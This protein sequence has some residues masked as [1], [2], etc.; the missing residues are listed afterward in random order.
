MTETHGQKFPDQLSFEDTQTLPAGTLS[1]LPAE[2]GQI[3]ITNRPA[4]NPEYSVTLSLL[5]RHLP[6]RCCKHR[7]L[8]LDWSPTVDEIQV[9]LPRDL[10][11]LWGE[12]KMPWPSEVWFQPCTT[13]LLIADELLKL[14]SVILGLTAYGRERAH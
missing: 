6:G 1:C 5:P 11:V 13:K 10:T 14:Y 3:Q 2:W 12:V 4:W 9:P 7:E 8:T